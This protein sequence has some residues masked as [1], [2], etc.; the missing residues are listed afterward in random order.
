MEEEAKEKLE[1]D[2]YREM[3]E[4]KGVSIT[5]RI[6]KSLDEYQV[7]SEKGALG[8]LF[9]AAMEKMKDQ[10]QLIAIDQKTRLEMIEE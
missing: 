7:Q 8:E 10:R 1:A 6:G 2:L 3:M 5:D 9:G 4:D